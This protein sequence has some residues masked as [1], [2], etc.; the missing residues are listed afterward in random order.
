[1]AKLKL[2]MARR[3]IIIVR[4]GFLMQ[5]FTFSCSI[6]GGGGMRFSYEKKNAKN[7][8]IFHYKVVG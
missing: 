2:D 3:G 4:V 7:W 8:L 1:M 6:G 5:V